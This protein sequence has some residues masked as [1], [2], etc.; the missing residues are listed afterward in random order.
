MKEPKTIYCPKCGRR[1]MKYSGEGT[2]PLSSRCDKCKK[3]I[4]YLPENDE[5]LTRDFPLR[6]TSS[7]M[8]FY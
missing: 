2:M 1:I 3:I 4:R 8:T 6:N 5:I 7:G